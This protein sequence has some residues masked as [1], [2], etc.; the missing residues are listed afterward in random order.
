[1][2][3]LTAAGCRN[4]LS[5]DPPPETLTP[6][7]EAPGVAAAEQ[8]AGSTTPAEPARFGVPFAWETSPDEPLAKARS[9]F[10]ETLAANDQL[11]ARGAKRFDEMSHGETPRATVIT[12]SDSHVQSDAWDS[13]PENDVFTVRNLGNQLSG[14]LGSVE[15]GVT[16]LRTPVLLIVG[17]TGCEAVRAA[18]DKPDAL[19]AA[20]REDLARLALDGAT[21]PK[22]AVLA[23]VH[24][25]VAASVGHF[26]GLVHSGE[27]T[28]IGAVYDARNEL[29]AGHGRLH[30]VNVNT[31]TD[32]GRIDAFVRAVRAHGTAAAK[33]GAAQRVPMEQRIR[34]IIE[35][36]ER[37]LPPPS[38]HVH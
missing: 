11:V 4:L 5:K 21:A 3:L 36:T 8:K 37:A 9:F 22:D 33:G 35:K 12:C 32:A 26:A 2:V 25:Q 29:G 18:R 28:V 24:A 6:A 13:S 38:R 14:A 15:Y 27:V 31:N 10:S 30:V 19:S 17:H 34:A 7:A 23:N 1:M 16:Q 20:I